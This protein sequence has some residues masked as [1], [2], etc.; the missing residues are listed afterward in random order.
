MNFPENWNYYYYEIKHLN[1]IIANERGFFFNVILNLAVQNLAAKKFEVFFV[2][3]ESVR[4]EIRKNKFEI[5]NKIKI[6]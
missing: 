3:F 1:F 5:S 2:L 6:K 4:D